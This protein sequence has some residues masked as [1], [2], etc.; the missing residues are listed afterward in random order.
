MTVMTV[1]HALKVLADK[2]V[3]VREQGR[4]TFVAMSEVPDAV[5]GT[6]KPICVLGLD[7]SL[8][9]PP[10]EI[11]WQTRMRRYQGIVNAAFH[12][13]L[14]IQTRVELNPNE[15][16]D[17]IARNLRRFSGVLLHERILSE[18]TILGLQDDGIPVVAM[19]CYVDSD[20]CSR[21][22]VN[23][24]QGAY[25]A[26]T[27]LIELGHTRIAA[28]VGRLSLVSMCERFE[29][30]RDALEAHGL[31][32]QPE[33]IIEEPRGRR[34]DG[35]AAARTLMKIDN[36]PT[37][38]FSVS[39]YRALGA[40][41]AMAELGVEVPK[42]LSVIG[43]DDI[44]EAERANPPLTTMHN[45]LYESG[46]TALHLLHDLMQQE[47]REIMVRMLSPKLVSRGSCAKPPARRKSAK[48]SASSS[49]LG[50]GRIEVWGRDNDARKS[51]AD[52]TEGQA[53]S[54]PTNTR[55]NTNTCHNEKRRQE[56]LSA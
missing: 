3:I 40:L 10:D 9:P 34:Q 39:D 5:N 33:L 41:E 42:Q 16:S 28:L 21:V 17:R 12:L 54:S 14:C 1:R 26:V 52:H 15:R 8:S 30:Y 2:G 46:H 6:R 25:R 18:A 55:S 4:G 20:S 56:P 31:S 51:T 35:A 36:P 27:Y 7:P 19:N 23:S 29:G 38:L 44:H 45:P 37:A 24:R 11:N 53:R 43:F 32:V 22:H 13:G 48:H 47:Q 50:G 49:P